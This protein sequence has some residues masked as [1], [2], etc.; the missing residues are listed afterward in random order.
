MH[1]NNLNK[2]TE[3]IKKVKIGQQSYT[4]GDEW[5]EL[6]PFRPSL[7]IEEDLDVSEHG[8]ESETAIR[9][10]D[11]ESL[12]DLV[13]RCWTEDAAQRPDLSHIKSDLRRINRQYVEWNGEWELRMGRPD[14]SPQFSS[15]FSCSVEEVE[16]K[17][18]N[19]ALKL[20]L[21]F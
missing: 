13:Q 8:K 2:C 6:C 19:Y 14:F 7:E 16:I 9:R 1:R 15:F 21:Y 12:F 4:N 17:L 10:R 20:N 11:L 18:S 5:T 3:I